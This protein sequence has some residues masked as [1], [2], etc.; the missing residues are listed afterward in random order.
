MIEIGQKRTTPVCT[1]TV[2]DGKR[3]RTPVL[4]DGVPLTKLVANEPV[5]VTRGTL[6]GHFG[7]DKNRR[8]VAAF[9]D[10]DLLELK[11]HGTRQR[12]TATLFDIYHWMQRCRADSARMERLTKRKASR[13]AA[14]ARRSWK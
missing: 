1:L 11:P 14:R 12:L 13:A 7:R 3:R 4:E 10:G 5:R 9:R 6:P 8:L 2:V